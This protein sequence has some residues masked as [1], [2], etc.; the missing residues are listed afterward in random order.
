MWRRSSLIYEIQIFW[1]EGTKTN[2]ER[3]DVMSEERITRRDALKKAAYIT[4]VILT[5]LA[6]PA[7]A[8]GGSGGD[9][10]RDEGKYEGR[11]DGGYEGNYEGSEVAGGGEIF[12]GNGKRGQRWLWNER[13]TRRERKKLWPWD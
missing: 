12:G 11:Y 13:N 1:I 5:F 3:S 8:S 4:P 2:F 6:A 7:F 10:R 9:E